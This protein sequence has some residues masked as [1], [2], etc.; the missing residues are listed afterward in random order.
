[1]PKQLELFPGYAPPEPR[2]VPRSEHPISRRM[3]AREALKVLYRLHD[4]GYL[5]YLVGGS[6]RDLLLGLTPK[7]FDVGTDARPE[8][9]RRLFRASRIIGRRF[10]LVHVYFRGG[11]I[12]EVVT[13]RGPEEFE[14]DQEVFGTPQ[15]DAFRRD[16]TINA[17]FYN[18]ADFTIIDYVGG[19]ED[20]RNGIIR[21]IGDPNVRFMRDP[22]RMLRAV[23][24]AARAGF[25][26]EPRTWEGILRHRE[27]IRLC[28][29][30][31]LRDEWL[32]DVTGGWAAP[33]LDLM[34]QSGLFREIFPAYHRALVNHPQLKNLL[35]RLLRQADTRIKQG[36]LSQAG[37]LVFFLYPYLLSNGFFSPP[38]KPTR[39]TR[40]VEK[41]LLEILGSYR[42]CKELF[43]ETLVLLSALLYY[44]YFIFRGKSSPKKLVRKSYFAELRELSDL[45]FPEE[46]KFLKI[47]VRSRKKR[48][49]RRRDA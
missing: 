5:A 34:F 44:R 47:E 6:V 15:E 17:L 21:V 38:E 13:F 30:I 25:E 3:I 1:M 14:E 37:A 27:K 46:R 19:L 8:E 35:T 11:K 33:W 28:S 23:R 4:A 32:K 10:R 18:I 42:F 20:L 39:P 22:V 12:V 49:K 29:P 26:I 24:H 31:R 9:I 40:E 43:E 45:I 36:K 7:D 2:I 48:R 16:L 41:R